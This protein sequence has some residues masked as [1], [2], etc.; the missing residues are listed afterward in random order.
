[1]LIYL[2]FNSNGV[3]HFV[4]QHRVQWCT[5]PIA[6]P[7]IHF[8]HGDRVPFL[9]RNQFWQSLEEGA[10]KRFS[11]CASEVTICLLQVACSRGTQAPVWWSALSTDLLTIWEAQGYATDKEL[12]PPVIQ[13]TRIGGRRGAKGGGGSAQGVRE[14]IDVMQLIRIMQ[15]RYSYHAE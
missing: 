9:W 13:C 11:E 3:R 14:I 12:G 5:W 7:E 10:G 6:D 4:T 2:L 15:L 8:V 1:M